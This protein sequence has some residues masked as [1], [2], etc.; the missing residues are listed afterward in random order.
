MCGGWGLTRVVRGQGAADGCVG[1]RSIGHSDLW[2]RKKRN[3]GQNVI[4]F[5]K[6]KNKLSGASDKDLRPGAWNDEGERVAG[7]SRSTD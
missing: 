2:K 5:N 4:F 6:C 1:G 3:S 7:Q